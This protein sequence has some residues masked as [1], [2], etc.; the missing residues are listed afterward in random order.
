M[1]DYTAAE[2]ERL[3]GERDIEYQRAEVFR[4]EN[5][6]LRQRPVYDDHIATMVQELQQ[7]NE[8]LREEWDRSLDRERELSAEVERLR[9]E[10]DA[11]TR[12]LAK[13]LPPHKLADQPTEDDP[14]WQEGY[15]AHH[16]E[17]CKEE[18]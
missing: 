8:R 6:R 5:E 9:E 4:D 14:A 17:H 12:D 7:E 10:R 15:S 11:L 16:E 13:R 18:A 2:V 1:S 3:R